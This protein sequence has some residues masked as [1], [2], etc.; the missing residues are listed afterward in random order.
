MAAF[1]VPWSWRRV[2]VDHM[3][4]A[5]CRAIKMPSTDCCVGCYLG[6]IFNQPRQNYG[7]S[8]R[9]LVL[10]AMTASGMVVGLSAAAFAVPAI[11]LPHSAVVS[12]S[13]L[14]QVDYNWHHQHWKHRDWDKRNHRWNYH[15]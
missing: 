14:E 7:V 11:P 4:V 13:G 5:G 6:M 12:S 10:S 9:K 15:N 1:C 3:F 8:M 2:G